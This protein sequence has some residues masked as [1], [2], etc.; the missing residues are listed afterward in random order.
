[1]SLFDIREGELPPMIVGGCVYGETSAKLF[2]EEARKKGHADERLIPIG[3]EVIT[4][5]MNRDEHAL[6]QALER[7]KA[8]EAEILETARPLNDRF[9]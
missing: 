7:Q 4:A 2:E 9:V 5:A 8:L 3:G 1:M 6:V